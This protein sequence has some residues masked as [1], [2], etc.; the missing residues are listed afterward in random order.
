M[1]GK[2][3]QD[4]NSSNSEFDYTKLNI[5]GCVHIWLVRDFWEG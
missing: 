5:E 3:L 1:G 4:F 2:L